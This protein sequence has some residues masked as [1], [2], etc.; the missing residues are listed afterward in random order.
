MTR[1]RVRDLLRRLDRCEGGTGWAD[2]RTMRTHLLDLLRSIGADGPRPYIDPEIEARWLAAQRPV[3][4]EE[5]VQAIRAVTEVRP[6]PLSG[7]LP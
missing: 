6:R 4:H 3:S 5:A 1:Q 2:D 7:D